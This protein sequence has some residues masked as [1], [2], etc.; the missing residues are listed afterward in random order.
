MSILILAALLLPPAPQ[1]P[2]L[3][4]VTSLTT[5]AAIAREI[6]GDRATVTAIAQGDE[7]P[8]HVQ[9]KPSFVALLRDADLFV[10]TGLDLELWVPPLLERAGNRK[11]SPGG[12]GYVTAYTG[13]ALLEVPSSVDRSQGDVHADGNPHLH[14]D[15]VNAIIISRNILTGLSRVAPGDAAYFTQRQKDFEQRVLEALMGRELV[16][17]LTPATAFQLA[18]TDQL[19]GF[20]EKTQLHGVPLSD[21]L[22]GWLKAAEVFRGREMVCYHRETAYFGHRFDI[23]CAAFIEPKPGLPPT[24]RHVESVIALVKERK[25]PVAFATVYYE[26]RQVEAVA[27]KTGARAV[28]LPEHT[29]GAPGLETYFNLLDAWVNGIAAG[30]RAGAS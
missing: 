19:R 13:V 14:T 4:V 28:I 17:I 10:T 11:V 20:I 23:S 22:G 18:F 1:A 2:P 5:Y 9:P 12:A 6:V 27:A 3:K 21:K 25:I 8:H 24:P 29:G 16:A 30:F 7:N 15:P 26:R